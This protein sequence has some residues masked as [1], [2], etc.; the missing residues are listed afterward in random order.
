MICG[1]TSFSISGT[2][3]ALRTSSGE[4][5]S[6]PHKILTHLRKEVCGWTGVTVK[7]S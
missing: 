6:V 7:S 1:H 5:I 3:P 4:V 2:L